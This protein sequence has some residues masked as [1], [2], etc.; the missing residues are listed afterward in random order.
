MGTYRAKQRYRDATPWTSFVRVGIFDRCPEYPFFREQTE[1]HG[2]HNREVWRNSRYLVS[3]DRIPVESLDVPVIHLQ[4]ESNNHHAVRDWRDFQRIKNELV[5]KE[6][7]ALEMY[8]AE[9]RLVDTCNTYHLWCVPGSVLPFGCMQ[10]MVSESGCGDGVQRPWELDVRP[11]DL[12]TINNPGDVG[13]LLQG[14]AW[15]TRDR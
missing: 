1:D 10:R 13:A 6:E 8:P 7:E 4:I 12:L 15:Q 2:N 9:S 11:S 5:G 3:V 14:L